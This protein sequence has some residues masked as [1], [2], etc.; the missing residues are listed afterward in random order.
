M[1]KNQEEYYRKKAIKDAKDAFWKSEILKVKEERP[2]VYH[3]PTYVMK[4]LE[5]KMHEEELFRFVL[6]SNS[7]VKV[8]LDFKYV[9]KI[10]EAIRE[11]EDPRP[12]K[13]F[14]D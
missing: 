10:V 2:S 3:K 6:K 9:K 11:E 5:Y 12:N 13:C 1:S 14:L 8:R 4:I 7:L